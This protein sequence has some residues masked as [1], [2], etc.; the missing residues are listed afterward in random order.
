MRLHTRYSGIRQN[1][2]KAMFILLG[3][4]FISIIVYLV[5]DFA[6]AK[7]R[8][9]ARRDEKTGDLILDNSW[10]TGEGGLLVML[11]MIIGGGIFIGIM[12]II[13][14]WWGSLID[15]LVNC[16]A[17]MA[18]ETIVLSPFLLIFAFLHFGRQYSITA[19]GIQ[20]RQLWLKTTLIKWSEIKAITAEG[21]SLRF[22]ISSPDKDI[23]LSFFN[24][25]L[26][27]FS[28]AVKEN[29]PYEKW[30]QA[31][32]YIEKFSEGNLN[33]DFEQLKS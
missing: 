17:F 3:E 7:R 21:L 16:L 29:L 1:E 32:E 2:G 27:D 25:G 24:H 9:Q 10:L 28:Q 11:F 6:W 13:E 4:F 14:D 8:P 23:K 22:V 31:A 20:Y 33:I 12:G 15:G 5:N 26:Q 30:G 19:E 18:T